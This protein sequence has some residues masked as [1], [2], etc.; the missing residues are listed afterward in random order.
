ML[1]N[2]NSVTFEYINIYSLAKSK[3][4]IPIFQRFYDWKEKQIIETLNDINDAIFNPLK[5][6]YLLDFIWYE[7]DGKKMIA[8]GQQ[9]LVSLNILIKCIKDYSVTNNLKAPDINLFN[10]SYDNVDYDKKYQQSFFN[11]MGS[12]F[13]KMYLYLMTYVEDNKDNLDEIINII[14]NR[15][16]IYLKKTSSSDEAFSIFTQINTGG[17]PLTKD[18]VIKTAID[19]YSVMYNVPVSSNVKELKKTITGYYKYISNSSGSNFDTIAI[20]GFLKNYIVKDKKTFKEFIDYLNIVSK[21]SEYS[22]AYIIEYINRSQLFDI[23]NVMAIKGINIKVKKDYLKD[24][25]F[26]LC[27]LSIVMTMKKSNP[28]GIIRT[29]YSKVIDMIKSDS[30]PID[31]CAEIAKFINENGEIC[32]ISY[33]DFVDCLGK[34]DFSTRI[35][36][37]ILIMDVISHTTSSDLNV[38]SINLEHIYPRNPSPEWAINNWPT[39][40]DSRAELIHNIGNYLLLNEEVNKKIQNKYIDQKIAEY[41]KIIPNDITL[42]TTLNTV[43]FDKFKNERKSYIIERQ[44]NIA[45]AVYANFKLANVIITKWGINYESTWIIEKKISST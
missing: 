40:P 4:G 24:V 15:I 16:Y 12:P 35:K 2:K 21:I 3:I 9:R 26:P 25:M 17:R 31:I 14:K 42:Q 32:K 20:M 19:Q 43:D 11:Y 23:L 28:G 27:L 33:N 30:K 5:D 34:R 45:F 22:I 36:E 44:K 7:E 13:K 10:I 39:D 29:L 38:P 37:A 18:E 8:D 41:N 6:I 1:T